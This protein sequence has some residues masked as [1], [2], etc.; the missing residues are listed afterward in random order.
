VHEFERACAR[1]DYHP[2]TRLVR[3]WYGHADYQQAIV[4]S[5][6]A[7]RAS[8][9]PDPARIELLFSA[10]GLPKKLVERGDPYEQQ[11]R[12]TFDALRAKLGWPHITLCYQSRVGPLEC[13]VLYQ[14]VIQQKATA[15]CRQMLVYPIAFV[16]DKRNPVRTCIQ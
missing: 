7:E 16:S 4:E 5:I 3:E 10:H 11:I 6:Q 15:G 14:D 12:A 2:R 13:C 8:C 1:Q 9:R